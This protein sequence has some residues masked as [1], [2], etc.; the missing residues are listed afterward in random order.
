MYL[1]WA[2]TTTEGDEGGT[3]LGPTVT[4]AQ[5][6]ATAFLSALGTNTVPM[7]VLHDPGLTAVGAPNPVTSLLV[8][9][10][11]GTQRR[12]LGR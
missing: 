11:V 8:D 10:R 4:A 7:V 9:N 6:K 3:L 12:R 5:A 1:P 2:I